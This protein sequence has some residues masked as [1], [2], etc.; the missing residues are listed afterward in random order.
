MKKKTHINKLAALLSATALAAPVAV[1]ADSHDENERAEIYGFVNLSVD[2]EGYEGKGD[3]DDGNLAMNTSLSHFGFRGQEELEDGLTAIYQA[4][5]EWNYT[6]DQEVAGNDGPVTQVRDS[7]V[8][9]EG[10]FGRL[11]LGR[12]AFGN[13]FVYD[14][15]NA[16]WVGQVGTAGGVL[17]HEAGGRLDNVIRYS[18]LDVGPLG[19]EFSLV[20]QAGTESRHHGYN[21]RFTYDEGPLSGGFTLW[22]ISDEDDYA[23]YSLG[24]R[25]DLGDMIVSGHFSGQIHDKDDND[26]MGMS[27]GL[28]IPWNDT[29]RIKGI[30]S[31]FLADAGNND[32]TNI[33]GGYDHIFSDRTKMRFALAATLN[34]ED[35][36]ATPYSYDMYGPSSGVEPAAD[37]THWTASVN[38][39]HS[40]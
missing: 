37:E 10:D 17:S 5:V 1:L 2:W 24:G 28:T 26:D 40:F 3:G 11:T 4:E 31:H 9:L 36:D 16:D 32:Y 38:L 19:A 7:F 22:Y 25:Y 8:G 27:F 21:A 15:P 14:G 18:E 29:G 39:R 23:I 35:S 33:A 30:V 12:Q 13:Q 34:D 20:P 6:G